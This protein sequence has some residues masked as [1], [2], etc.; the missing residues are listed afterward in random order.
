MLQ[1]VAVMVS[2]GLLA[3]AA[4]L[5][6]VA[7]WLSSARV[8]SELGSA[9]LVLTALGSVLA[10]FVISWVP[11]VVGLAVVCVAYA[12]LVIR[13]RRDRRD[14]LRFLQGAPVFAHGPAWCLGLEG[15]PDPYTGELATVVGAR[16]V[17]AAVKSLVLPTAERQAR[18]TWAVQNAWRLYTA[19]RGS[20]ARVH[21]FRP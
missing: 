6:V 13:A 19:G 9:G 20:S 10:A 12:W 5:L 21:P 17:D 11:V 18:L 15:G 8:A 7:P 4:A 3:G 1:R 14:L 2:T 16:Q